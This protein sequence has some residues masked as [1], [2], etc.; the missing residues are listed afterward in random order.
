MAG[1]KWITFS[2][3]DGTVHDRRM[4]EVF[5]RFRLKGTFN[6]NSDRM[7]TKHT[8]APIGLIC[9]HSEI[10]PQDVAEVYRNHEVAAHGLD[11]RTFLG[12]SDQALYAEAELDRQALCKMAE[13]EVIGCAY[14]NGPYDDRV[15]QFLREKTN[16]L[17]ARTT[18]ET[19]H[20]GLP[21]DFLEWHPTA[22]ISGDAIFMLMDRF[23]CSESEEDQLLCI[24]GHSYNFDMYHNWDKLEQVCRVLAFR[25]DCTY[26][27]M[28]EIYRYY[29]P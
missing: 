17:Y 18:R 8:Y 6:L 3:D 4:I 27:T 5:D 24:W 15:V 12:L 9:D 10:E 2:F 16:I 21:A 19:Y 25:P 1:K 7:G 13:Q 20:F 11:H 29:N 28:G 14:P 26:A 22:G 23:L